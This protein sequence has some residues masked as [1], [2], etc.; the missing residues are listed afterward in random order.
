MRG[1][2]EARRKSP[3]DHHDRNRD[4]DD[5]DHDDD[6]ED[7]DEKVGVCG[8]GGLRWTGTTDVSDCGGGR[9]GARAVRGS[10][11]RS[12]SRYGPRLLES[13]F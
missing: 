11:V 7:E 8:A 2:G 9:A 13:S 4:G 12:N 3:G 1:E 5:D 10:G 6:D